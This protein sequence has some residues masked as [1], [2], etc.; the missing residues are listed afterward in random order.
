MGCMKR[1]CLLILLLLLLGISST[2]GISMFNESIQ[3]GNTKPSVGLS[4]AY[5]ESTRTFSAKFTNNSSKTITK[6]AVTIKKKDLSRKY[7]MFDTNQYEYETIVF[8]VN[9]PSG[10]STIQKRQVSMGSNYQYVGA[11]VDW[12]K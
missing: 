10:S 7:D 4:C 11:F 12:A 2:K 5:N 1:S 6:I 3:I 9:I 8:D